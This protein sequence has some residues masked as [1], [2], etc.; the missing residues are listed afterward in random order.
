MNRLYGRALA[1][2]VNA[3]RHLYPGTTTLVLALAALLPPVTP[4]AAA[5]LTGALVAFDASLGVNGTAFT[6]LYDNV[7]GFRAFRVPARFGML[8]G[9]FLTLLAGVGLARIRNRWPGRISERLAV[10]LVAVAAF[11]LRPALPLRG[12][13]DRTTAIYAALPDGGNVVLVDLPLPAD[14]G[15]YLDRSDVPCTTRRFTG[16]GCS[17]ATAD[18]RRSWY[19]RLRRRLA[20]V[21]ERRVDRRLPRPAP[22]ISSCTR[23]SIASAGVYRRRHRAPGRARA[24]A[25]RSSAP[26]RHL[27]PAG[28]AP[29]LYRLSTVE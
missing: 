15:E 16:A 9:L 21:S 5:G 7:P 27:P 12:D 28:G 11:E 20:R 17:T 8:L 4:L 1:T 3:E 19:P 25:L 23:S 10:A 22:S 24:D 26:K 14:D 29:R 2:D 13:A 18:S 6:W